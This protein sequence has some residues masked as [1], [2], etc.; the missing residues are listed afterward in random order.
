M[1]EIILHAAQTP[2][3]YFLKN[4]LFLGGIEVDNNYIYKYII[5]FF[6]R[7]IPFDSFFY[8]IVL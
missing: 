6:M 4:R 3:L 7:Y 1:S 2:K 5:L 8:V